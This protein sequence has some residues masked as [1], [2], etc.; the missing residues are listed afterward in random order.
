MLRDSDNTA[1][2]AVAASV[3]GLVPA[4]EIP[5]RFLDVDF[6]QNQDFTVSISARSYSSFLKCL[7]FSCYLDKDHSQELIQ[8]LIDSTAQ[9]R[10]RAGIDNQM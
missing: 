7:Y 4:E 5:F 10:L 6:R 9:N 1:L 3:V 2:K 8:Y